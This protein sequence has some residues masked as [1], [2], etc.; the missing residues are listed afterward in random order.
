MSISHA[1]ELHIKVGVKRAREIPVLGR[2]SDFVA[3]LVIG[4][5]NHAKLVGV[6]LRSGREALAQVLDVV[7]GV[8]KAVGLIEKGV[9][10]VV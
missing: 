1:R 5:Q 2:R 10:P 9:L 3:G 8:Q 6:S 7:D 4:R